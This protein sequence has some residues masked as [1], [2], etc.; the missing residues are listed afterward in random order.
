MEPVLEDNQSVVF[1]T[2]GYTVDVGDVV[3]YTRNNTRIAHRVVEIYNDTGT[4]ATYVVTK[5]DANTKR[6]KPIPLYTVQ[7]ELH[8]ILDSPVEKYYY[9][10]AL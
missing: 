2:V 5:G 10:L 8:K 4:G 3:M 9:F 7:G 6:D 1:K